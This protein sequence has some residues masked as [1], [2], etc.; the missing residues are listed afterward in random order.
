[1]LYYYSL[2]KV[3]IRTRNAFLWNIPCVCGLLAL[4]GVPD[5]LHT[6]EGGQGV[7]W[8]RTLARHTLGLGGNLSLPIQ[9][10][11]ACFMRQESLV[12]LEQV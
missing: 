5:H 4:G 8:R 7:L 12:L 10:R 9:T 1:M 11:H 6:G 2:T 3:F